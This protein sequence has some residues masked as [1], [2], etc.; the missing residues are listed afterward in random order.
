MLDKMKYCPMSKYQEANLSK[1][2]ERKI[3]FGKII[4]KNFPSPPL[5]IIFYQQRYGNWN[6]YSEKPI[7]TMRMI[8]YCEFMGLYGI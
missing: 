8:H 2:D 1:D 5:K 6:A 4:F 3:G 7:L